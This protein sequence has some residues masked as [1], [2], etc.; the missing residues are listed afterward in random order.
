MRVAT[1]TPVGNTVLAGDRT[2]AVPAPFEPLLPSGLVRGRVVAA[3]GP[4]ATALAV[5][6]VTRAVVDGAWLAA[7]DMPWLGAEAVAEHG[8]PLERVVRVD[9]DGHD[10]AMW[11]RAVDAALGGFDIVLAAPPHRAGVAVARHLHARARTRGGVVV[12]VGPVSPA[13]PV[14]L[15]IDTAAPTW[16]QAGGVGHLVAR[17]VTVTVS[18]RRQPDRRRAELLLP[19]PDGAAAFLVVPAA[20]ESGVASAVLPALRSVG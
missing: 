17:R 7:I 3:T 13:L 15:V 6:L 18:G 1:T 19:G 20:P 5:A 4:A 12:L 9:V 14:D 16:T 8:V 2:I 10:P 11:G